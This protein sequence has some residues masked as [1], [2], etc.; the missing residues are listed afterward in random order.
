MTICTTTSNSN[1]E[2]A[3]KKKR[4]NKKDKA[5]EVKKD[6]RKKTFIFKCQQQGH[7]QSQRPL[8]NVNDNTSISVGPLSSE[9][10]AEVCQNVS[11]V[12]ESDWC[13]D[14]GKGLT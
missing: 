2:N 7:R 9:V 4:E 14:S 13:L 12:T 1:Q 10:I 3:Q 6:K 5:N 8:K 11:K